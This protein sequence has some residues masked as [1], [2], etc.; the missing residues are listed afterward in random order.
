MEGAREPICLTARE[1]EKLGDGE[2]YVL[3]YLAVAFADAH[4]AVSLEE[5]HDPIFFVKCKK[6]HDRLIIH[7]TRNFGMDQKCICKCQVRVRPFL[8]GVPQGSQCSTNW[9]IPIHSIDITRP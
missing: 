5:M 2:L 1:D 7:N 9:A 4:E 6:S 3:L 8:S